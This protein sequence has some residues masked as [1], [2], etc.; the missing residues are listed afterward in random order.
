M[1][2]STATTPTIESLLS[3]VDAAQAQVRAWQTK[4]AL[5]LNDVRLALTAFSVLQHE[6]FDDCP[7]APEMLRTSKF[8]DVL[9]FA[10]VE[11]GFLRVT[12]E[13][14]SRGEVNSGDF[15]IPI[16][17]LGVDGRAVMKQEAAELRVAH[18]LAKAERAVRDQESRRETYARLCQEFAPERPAAG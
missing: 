7:Y 9:V 4:K 3:V 18:A 14:N 12:T 17:Y 13:W 1:T 11:D 16:R 5:A 15:E 10:E 8:D 6:I 2:T